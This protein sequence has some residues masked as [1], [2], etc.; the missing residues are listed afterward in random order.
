MHKCTNAMLNHMHA[1][2]RNNDCTMAMSPSMT[3]N[4]EPKNNVNVKEFALSE[5]NLNRA[6]EKLKFLY[7]RP[8]LCVFSY[9]NTQCSAVLC[10]VR[11]TIGPNGCY[12]F[13]CF[14][15]H[16]DS[17]TYNVCSSLNSDPFINQNLGLSKKCRMRN[18]FMCVPPGTFRQQN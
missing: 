15:L 14:P 8:V 12:L 18:L 5:K 1:M 4:Q 16:T 9:E 10:R 3:C 17:F 7:V 13:L 6:F 2:T 11:K